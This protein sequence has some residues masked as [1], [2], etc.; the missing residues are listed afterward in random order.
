MRS[1]A[2][3]ILINIWWYYFTMY[4]KIRLGFYHR[5]LF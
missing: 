2:R 1:V 5:A 3:Y 4:L